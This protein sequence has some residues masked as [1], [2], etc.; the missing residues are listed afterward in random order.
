MN[1]SHFEKFENESYE[2]YT[3]LAIME[4]SEDR[5]SIEF[6]DFEGAFVYSDIDNAISDAEILLEDCIINYKIDGVKLPKSTEKGVI[7]LNQKK[8]KEIFITAY[9]D[10][11]AK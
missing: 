6:P 4:F 11:D 2:Q 7:K 3:Y 1:N 8:E 5:V 9:V 10:I